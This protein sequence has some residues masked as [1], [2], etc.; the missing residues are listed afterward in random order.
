MLLQ[1]AIFHS[2]WLRSI[3]VCVC[4]YTLHIFIIHSPI[5]G[6]LGNFHILAITNNAV[7]NTGV[8]VPFQISNFTFFG[9]I[10]R[11]GIAVSWQLTIAGLLNHATHCQTKSPESR[12]GFHLD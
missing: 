6:H 7:M 3:R 8:H 4:V 5:N 1:M 11:S 2:L 10:H 12:N 9:Y